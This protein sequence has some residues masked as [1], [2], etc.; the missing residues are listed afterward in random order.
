MTDPTSRQRQDSNFQKTTFGQKAISGHKSQS[1]LDTLTYWLTDW[2]TVSC[3]VTST[4]VL[5]SQMGSWHQGRLPDYTSPPCAFVQWCLI[6][7]AQGSFTLLSN[8]TSDPGHNY[9]PSQDFPLRAFSHLFWILSSPD[10]DIEWPHTWHHLFPGLN[11]KVNIV[12]HEEV[13]LVA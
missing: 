1:G 9:R 10:Y 12:K 11:A 6:N 4:S 3:N 5:V 7:E 13:P 2:P 8:P